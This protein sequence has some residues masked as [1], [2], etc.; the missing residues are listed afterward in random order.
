[1][2]QEPQGRR[3]EGRGPLGPAGWWPLT[4]ETHS[5]KQAPGSCLTSYGNTV[6][7]SLC[8]SSQAAQLSLTRCF[9]CSRPAPRL[10]R[11]GGQL[12]APGGWAVQLGSPGSG[13]VHL[14]AAALPRYLQSP[15]PTQPA[16]PERGLLW[17]ASS[18]AEALRGGG[19]PTCPRCPLLGP[20]LPS[21]PVPQTR[22][23]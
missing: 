15:A 19:D 3:M 23:Q 16:S 9:P 7:A 13:H 10:Q 21:H 18:L 1:M 17:S 12:R 20:S 22:G 14:P 5:W 6:H 11:S 4:I 8:P 2:S